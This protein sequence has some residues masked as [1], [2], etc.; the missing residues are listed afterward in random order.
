MNI[1]LDFRRFKRVIRGKDDIDLTPKEKSIIKIIL[2]LI[3]TGGYIFTFMSALTAV[4]VLATQ[5]YFPREIND[6]EG[7]INHIYCSV[8]PG[9]D[10]IK[11]Y[12]IAYGTF[13]T[14]QFLQFQN[15]WRAVNYEQLFSVKGGQ[16]LS[17]YLITMFAKNKSEQVEYIRRRLSA[18]VR[19]VVF[20]CDL[21]CH[22]L[23]VIFTESFCRRESPTEQK[24]M[25]VFVFDGTEGCDAIAN[26]YSKELAK[27]YHGVELS[28]RSAWGNMRIAPAST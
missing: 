10:F 7:G 5:Y 15:A 4:K 19:C 24:L 17:T 14:K 9:F 26:C 28:P 27:H 11:Y 16:T 2:T 13:L 21:C 3:F 12:G 18:V 8:Y 1:F 20:C 22:I 23:Y 6:H 25:G